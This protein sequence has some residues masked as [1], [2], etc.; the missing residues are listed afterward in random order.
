MVNKALLVGRVC[1]APELKSTPSG[2]QVCNFR[3]AVERPFG[4]ANGEKETDFIDVVCWRKTAEFMH[5]Y[6]D[7]GRLIWVEGRI[8]VRQWE[9]ND[10]QKRRATEI[11]ADNIRPLDKPKD[12]GGQQ[13]GNEY[14]TTR[15]ADQYDGVDPFADVSDPF[16]GQ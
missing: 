16:A 5:Q 4:G 14:G 12:G 2:V 13:R 1:T 8:Q 7:K 3:L 15:E 10:G 6:V 11:V 9:T